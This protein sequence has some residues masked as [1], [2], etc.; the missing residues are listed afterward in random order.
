MAGDVQFD[1]RMMARALS[2]AARGEGLVEPN[3]MVGCVITQ[4]QRIVGEGWHARFGGDHAEIAALRQAGSAARGGTLYVT[5]EPCCHTGKTPPCTQAV[6]QHGLQRVV[7]AVPDPFPPVAGA[8]LEQLRAAG[9]EVQV[10][11]GQQKARQ[12][13]APYLH[14][15]RFRRPWV[16]AKWAMTWDGKLATSQG[17]SRWISNEASRACAHTLRGRM[18]AILV[19]RGTV[20]ADDPLL[21]A[22]PAGPRLPVRVVLDSSATLA[23]TC[24]LIQ[25]A[26]EVPVLVAAAESAPPANVRRLTAA[27]CEVWQAAGDYRQRLELL[28]EEL[29]RRNMT[30]VLVEGGSRLLGV[31]FDAQRIDEVHVFLA[32]K[33]VGG[34]RAPS[35]IAGQGLA[36]MARACRLGHLSYE[37]VDGDLYAHGRVA[38]AD[39]D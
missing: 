7:A 22:R 2:L 3:P 25:T 8:G 34:A 38:R 21:T 11:V 33:I 32:P 18:D 5:L 36:L 30:N 27:G 23:D 10:G 37:M 35:P 19:G 24:R 6:L 28:L 39:D 16:L 12:L 31:C 4:G 17:E 29:G 20:E 14:R 9:V 26:R 13:L 15:L 1:A